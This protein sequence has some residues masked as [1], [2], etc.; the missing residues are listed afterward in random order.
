[1]SSAGQPG[2]PAATWD[3]LHAEVVPKRLRRRQPSAPR[4]EWPEQAVLDQPAAAVVLLWGAP[5]SLVERVAATLANAGA[6]VRADRFGAQPPTDLV[7][8]YLTIDGLAS[9][10]AGPAAPVPEWRPAAPAPGS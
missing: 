2:A 6:P 3:E 1:P 7:Q 10:S 9:G 4:A 5:G 8:R